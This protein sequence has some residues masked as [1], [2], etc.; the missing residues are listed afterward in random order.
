LHRVKKGPGIPPEESFM[1]PWIITALALLLSAASPHAHA[2]PATRGCGVAD[3]TCSKRILWILN[4][5]HVGATE[6]DGGVRF[7]DGKADAA[8]RVSASGVSADAQIGDLEALAFEAVY[9]PEAG[10]VRVRFTLAD[11]DVLF[12]CKDDEGTNHPPLL[13]F[14]YNCEPTGVIGL[15]GTL[16]EL[17][18]DEATHRFGARWAEVNFVLNFLRNGNGMDYLKKRLLAYAGTSLDT[19]WGS[20]TPGANDETDTMLRLNLGI[21][22]MI[23]SENNRWEIRALAG[24]RPNVTDWSDVGFEAKTQILYHLLFN[25]SALGTVGLEG[26]F[27]HWGVPWHSI[28][29]FA[30]DR[31]RN[32]FFLRLMFSVVF[33]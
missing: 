17:Q 5:I 18:W 26:G 9:V 31:D 32:N 12:F 25:R 6:V 27:S 19:V 33:Q 22:G 15:G 28:D 23:R 11:S 1:R 10:G 4:G 16:A 24:Y 21:M 14:F 2:E 30:S 13:A 7:G 8:I 3:P 20:G 29:S